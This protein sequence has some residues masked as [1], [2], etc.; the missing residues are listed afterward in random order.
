MILK[1]TLYK[2]ID[3]LTAFG[4]KI[5]P[6]SDEDEERKQPGVVQRRPTASVKQK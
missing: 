4:E 5:T 1:D 6:G 2:A 3:A